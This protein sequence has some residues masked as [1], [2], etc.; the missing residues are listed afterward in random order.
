MKIIRDLQV[1]YCPKLECKGYLL[2]PCELQYPMDRASDLTCHDMELLRSCISQSKPYIL[3][4]KAG[5]PSKMTELLPIEPE[6]YLTIY[7]VS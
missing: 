1:K 4:T 3:S 5:K 2:S 7:E 6:R